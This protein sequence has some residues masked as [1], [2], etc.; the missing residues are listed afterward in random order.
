MKRLVALFLVLLLSIEG[1]A[2]VVSDNDGSAFITKAEFDSLKNNFQS[3]LDQYNTSIDSKIDGAIAS[4]LSGIKVNQTSVLNI[5]QPG[6][7]ESVS[8]NDTISNNVWRYKYGSPMI[9]M[10]YS[11]WGSSDAGRTN[12]C[13]IVWTLPYPTYAYNK[14]GQHKLLLSTVNDL[15]GTAE[16]FGFSFASS[17]RINLINGAGNVILYEMGNVTN[18][19]MGYF[20]PSYNDP[21]RTDSFQNVGFENVDIG[22]VANNTS[23]TWEAI[24]KCQSVSHDWGVVQKNAVMLLKASKPYLNFVR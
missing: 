17:D 21:V 19:Y 16:W 12:C 15:N 22:T 11:H 4:Y 6:E 5:L 10:E 3:Q 18:Y 23:F 24:L 13:G 20:R 1:F 8:Y 2:A 9:Y 14:H 7:Y